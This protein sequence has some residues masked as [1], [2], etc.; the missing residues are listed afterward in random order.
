MGVCAIAP[1]RAEHAS[2]RDFILFLYFLW[3]ILYFNRMK[4][5]IYRSVLF[6]LLLISYSWTMLR[7]SLSTSRRYSTP[8]SLKTALH[9]LHVK[10]G[11]KMVDFAGWSM[12]VHYG[13]VTTEHVHTRQRCSLFDVGHMLQTVP[14]F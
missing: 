5:P 3:S 13:S 12:P 9:N 14:H 8:T 7:L 6:Y 4:Y 10:N 1:S 11:A 2:F